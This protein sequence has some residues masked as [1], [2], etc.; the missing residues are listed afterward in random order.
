[1]PPPQAPSIRA[2][3][4]P[5]GRRRAIV[6]AAAALVVDDGLVDLTHRRVAERAGVPLGATTYYF[7]S[8][9][10]LAEAALRHLADGIDDELRELAQAL[11]ERG[12]EPDVLAELLHVY[13]SDRDAV[14]KDSALYFAG[15]KDPQL[16]VHTL[17]WFDGL[18]SVLSAHMSPAK[19]RALAVFTDGAFMQ[20][21]LR[22]EPMDADELQRT[23]ATLLDSELLDDDADGGAR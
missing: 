21:A 17:R 11:E 3:R 13:L 15:A 9:A 2:R 16:L 7:A 14:R 22:D 6:E 23:V 5:E 19:A 12:A 18:V 20:A 10:E 1:M 8:L 4:D